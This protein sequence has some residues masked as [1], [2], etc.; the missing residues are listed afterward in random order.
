[1]LGVCWVFGALCI[2]V[3]CY[4]TISYNSVATSKGNL[5][6]SFPFSLSLGLGFRALFLS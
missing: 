6:A 4:S 2:D 3:F 1:M 5:L